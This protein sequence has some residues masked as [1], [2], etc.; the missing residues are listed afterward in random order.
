MTLET[1]AIQH[2]HH[3]QVAYSGEVFVDYIRILIGLLL[4]GYET[5]SRG[6]CISQDGTFGLYL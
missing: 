6:Y 2:A 4:A 3:P 1:V 5:L